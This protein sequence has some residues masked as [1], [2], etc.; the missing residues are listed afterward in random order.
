MCLLRP[1]CRAFQTPQ[2]DAASDIKSNT[3]LG[4]EL[5]VVRAGWHQDYR[6]IDVTQGFFSSSNRS[7]P[8][9]VSRDSNRKIVIFPIHRIGDLTQKFSRMY[10]P[11]LGDEI[12]NLRSNEKLILETR[13]V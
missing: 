5:A 6:L 12:S 13:V 3:G 4:D 7:L 11:D 8:R 2:V 10:P 1:G 9:R